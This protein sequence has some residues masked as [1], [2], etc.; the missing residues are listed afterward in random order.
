MIRDNPPDT[1]RNQPAVKSISRAASILICL[2][3]GFN[4][5]TDIASCC[6]L[7]KSTVHRLL[8]ALE[9]TYIVSQDPINHHYYLGPLV[10]RLS[11]K[12]QNT[13]EYL[14]ISSV[15][16]MKYLADIAEETVT[17][18]VMNG[19]QYAH[20][21]EILSKHDLR[22]TEEGRRVRPFFAGATTKVLLSQLN[23]EELKIAIRNIRITPVTRNTVTDKD[24]LMTQVKK[25]RRQGYAISKGEAIE[26]A[27]AISAPIRDYVIPAALS[28]VGPENRLQPRVASLTEE[29]QAS[30]SHISNTMAEIFQ[31]KEAV[32]NT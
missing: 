1:D 28:I 18:A 9:E 13:H 11:T 7:S 25:V 19:I 8:K 17:L 30:A 14:I 5:I 12:Q 22:V 2:D 26:G 3:N 32:V 23:D 24:I 20:L 16:E 4:T 29:L 10:T 15:E 6:K 21:H 31:A 27:L